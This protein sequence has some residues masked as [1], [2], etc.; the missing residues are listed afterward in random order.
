MAQQNS[1]LASPLDA[2]TDRIQ[3]ERFELPPLPKEEPA[4]APAQPQAAAPK[5]SKKG[6]SSD[7]YAPPAEFRPLFESA[8]RKYNVP[9]NVLM[10]LGHQESRFN[11]TAIGVPTKRGRAKGMM[12]YLDDTASRLGINPFEPTEAIDA[13]AKQI[14]QRL[15]K[16]YSME[17]A[18]KAH[19]ASDN[20]RL[21]KKKTAAYGSEVLQKAARIADSLYPFDQSPE[22]VARRDRQRTEIEAQEVERDRLQ[23]PTA[24]QGL[25]MPQDQKAIDDRGFFDR[26]GNALSSGYDNMVQS[27]NTARFAVAG[28]DSTELAR[29]LSEKFQREANRPKTTGEK[30]IDAAFQAVTDANGAWDTVKAGAKA[31]GTAITNPKDLA[32]GIVEQAPNMLPT[33][34]GGAGGAGA[35]GAAGAGVG[36]LFGGVGALPGAATGAIW[37]GRAGMVAGTTATELGAEVEQMILERLQAQKAAPTEQNIK[38]LLD[39]QAFQSEARTRGLKKG[40]TVA[41]VDQ[42]FLGLGGK[43]ASA[44]ARQAAKTGVAPTLGRRAAAGGAAIG[45][46]ATGEVVGEAASQKVARGEVDAGD[47]LREGVYG[48]GQ[49]IVEPTIG[50]G[51][52]A[53]KRATTDN[54]PGAQVGRELD[55][56]VSGTQFSQDEINQQ[57]VAALDPNQS[58]A[59]VQQAA[60]T[61]TVTAPAPSQADGPLTRAVENAA[62]QPQRVTVTAPEGEVTGF[63]LDVTQD[64]QGNSVT[65]V[66]GDDGQTYNF[67]SADAVEIKPES[68]PLTKALEKVAAKGAPQPVNTGATANDDLGIRDV[69]QQGN[70]AAAQAGANQQG[71]GAGDQAGDAGMRGDARAFEPGARAGVLG[72]DATADAQPALSQQQAALPKELAGAKPRY[73]FGSKQ[74]D[75]TFANDIDRA[76]YIAAQ[77]TPSKRDA[78]YVRFVADATGMSEEE[79]RAHGAKVREAIKAQARDAEPGSLSVPSVYAATA[80]AAAPAAAEPANLEAMTEPELRAQLKAVAGQAK[81]AGWTPELK[82]Q[83]RQIE[84]RINKL[85][86]DDF[87]SAIDPAPADLNELEAKVYADLTAAMNAQFGEDVAAELIERAAVMT[88]GQSAEQ[89]FLALEGLTNDRQQQTAESIP[90]GQEPIA[91]QPAEGSAGAAQQSQ[92]GQAEEVAPAKDEYAGKWFGSEEKA[93]AFIDKKKAGATHEAVQTGKVRWEIKP[94]AAQPAQLDD[95]NVADSATVKESLTAEPAKE[96]PNLAP[97]AAQPPATKEAVQKRIERISRGLRKKRGASR[98]DSGYTIAMAEQDLADIDAMRQQ[99]GADTEALDDLAKQIDYHV[100]MMRKEEASKQQAEA[101]PITVKKGAGVTTIII[102]PSAGQ[103]PAKQQDAPGTRVNG[104]AERSAAD[105]LEKLYDQMSAIT[106]RNSLEGNAKVAIRSMIEELRRPKTVTNVVGVLEKASSDLMRKYGAFAQVVQE[107]A[108]SLDGKQDE[109]KPTEPTPPTGGKKGQFANNKIFTADK[110]EAA[111]AR[112]KQKLSGS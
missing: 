81:E 106:N 99:D 105:R 20:R 62:E 110:V 30:E 87:T 56:A 80:P 5:Q 51:I 36:A 28:G 32:V 48:L 3:Q 79:V 54:S 25:P 59:P 45:L 89:F 31:V 72:A 52:E 22:E 14:R 41:L 53:A 109:A 111:R 60:P 82:E 42:I 64:D 70:Q 96:V 94:K 47:A 9:V 57:A 86:T 39:N 76:A 93:Q 90:A 37:G 63:V 4:A 108:D 78:D 97:A 100:G 40:L 83:R 85:V 1:F 17:D 104:D 103:K 23:Q 58:A 65:R 29:S 71:A 67:T 13:A 46:D 55:R 19:F 12:Q 77:K 102:D 101:K 66:L 8:A 35:G 11:P 61:V 16:G 34:A 7:D 2:V 84:S 112:L 10:A 27:L 15:D 6:S 43:V 88:D 21:W 49:S 95:I 26:A 69:G 74:F 75:L 107:V 98:G 92:E 33:V 91:S 38:A 50:A 24:S 18:V 44:P 73:S 68:G